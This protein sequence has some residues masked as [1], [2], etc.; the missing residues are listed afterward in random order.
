MVSS[1]G[2]CCHGDQTGLPTAL[3]NAKGGDRPFSRCLMT[4]AH[5]AN[6][7]AHSPPANVARE[8]E[9]ARLAVSPSRTYMPFLD[10]MTGALTCQITIMW[11]PS[12]GSTGP[13]PPRCYGEQATRPPS[14]QRAWH[15]GLLWHRRRE[16]ERTPRLPRADTYATIL[17]GMQL[18]GQTTCGFVRPYPAPCRCVYR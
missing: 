5:P 7:R 13:E 3:G 17:G 2:F 4:A 12:R 16:S 1:F 15:R 18:E 10:D 14:W 9:G 6:I 11:S 8:A